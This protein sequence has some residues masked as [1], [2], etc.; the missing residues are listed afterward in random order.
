MKMKIKRVA[1]SPSALVRIFA[2]GTTWKVSKG[3]PED[4]QIRVFTLDPYTQVLYLFVEHDSFEPTEVHSPFP[5]LE[6]EFVRLS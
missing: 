6:T 4:A 3:I 2:L 1:I 5:L